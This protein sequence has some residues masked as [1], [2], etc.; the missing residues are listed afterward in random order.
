MKNKRKE[1][2]LCIGAF[3]ISIN[4]V[5]AQKKITGYIMSST[6]APVVDAVISYQHGKSIRSAS[7][8]SFTVDSIKAGDVMNIWHE[9]FFSKT[10][11]I[12]NNTE[13][14]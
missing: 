12:D 14:K 2:L 10:V 8:G 9:G 11:Y 7:D 13:N 4:Y 1:I 6:H 5:F 3:M